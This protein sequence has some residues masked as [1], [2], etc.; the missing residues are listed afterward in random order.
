MNFSIIDG[1]SLPVIPLLHR[2]NKTH[3]DKFGNISV[4]QK[5]NSYGYRT[6]EFN[7][8]NNEYGLVIGCS[9]TEGKATHLE[10]RYSNLLENKLNLQLINLGLGASSATICKKNIIAWTTSQKI[11]PKFVI[12]QW[13]NPYRLFTFNHTNKSTFEVLNGNPGVISKSMLK[14]ST[15]NFLEIWLSSIIDTN[16]ILQLLKIPCYNIHFQ[17]KNEV[18]EFDIDIILK[19]HNIKMYL[20]TDDPQKYWQV[21]CAAYDKSHHSNACHQ[22]WANKLF[23]IINEST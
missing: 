15:H 21:D 17:T 4:E 5:Y 2:A 20:N 16:K 23:E 19:N 14:E 22:Q 1:F 3:T 7:N 12:I 11:L 18:A 8:L 10:Q 6:H 9:H 13:P